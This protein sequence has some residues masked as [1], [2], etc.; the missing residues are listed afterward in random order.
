MGG[1][2]H[3][4]PLLKIHGFLRDRYKYAIPLA[5]ALS[6][7]GA[8]AGYRFTVP[9]Y[10]STGAVII[11]SN[12]PTIMYKTDFNSPMQNFDAYLALQVRLIL[13]RRTIDIA[14]QDPE[15]QEISKG[16][17]TADA[18]TEFDNK[19]SAGAQNGGVIEIYYTD[20]DPKIAMKA[21]RAVVAAYQK[22]YQESDA[23]NDVVRQK[24][25]ED[26]RVT[27]TNEIKSLTDSINA[28]SPEYGPDA[29]RKIYNDKLNFL[30]EIETRY[31]K[32]EL[33]LKIA[34]ATLAKKSPQTQPAGVTAVNAFE[35]QTAEQI[36]VY[37]PTM[38]DIMSRFRKISVELKTLETQLGSKHRSVVTL[39][40]AKENLAKQIQ[41]R[42][43]EINQS[44]KPDTAVESFI[45]PGEIMGVS[46]NTL[47]QKE[48][49]ERDLYERAK[50]ETLDLGRKVTQIDSLMQD[51]AEKE[52]NRDETK[53]RLDQIN[54]EAIVSG[55][56]NVLDPGNQ[57]VHPYNDKRIR[58][59]GVAGLGGALLG[60]GVFALVGLLDRRVKNLADIESAFSR[61]QRLLGIL[62]TLPD[63]LADP[64]QAAFAAHCVHRIRTMMEVGAGAGRRR[65]VTITS[66][67]PGDGKTSLTLALGLSFAAADSKTLLIDCD[68]V[69]GGLTARMKTIIRRKMGEILRRQGLLTEAQFENAL[70]ETQRTGKKLGEVIVE[71]GY[72]TQND[73]DH[74]LVMQKES[75]VGLLDV[76][77][78]APLG[79]SITGTGTPGLSILPLGSARAHLT[80][81]ISPKA[82]RRIIEEARQHYDVTLIDTGPLLGS[83]E[84]SIIATEADEVILAVARGEQRPLVEKAIEMLHSIGARLTG[85][86]YNRAK[87][88]DIESSDF[89]PSTRLSIMR[90]QPMD[91]DLGAAPMRAEGSSRLGPVAGAVVTSTQ[92]PD[93]TN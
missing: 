55:R 28:V 51:R 73:I 38:K 40:L 25:L 66:P 15:W 86:V 9:K 23:Q 80:G 53:K 26:R 43:D 65:V 67:M 68:V 7:A 35:S 20:P 41:E 10:R 82:I 71:L 37:D 60:L 85:V 17:F 27:L 24:A 83:L 1:E 30:N 63:D 3:V 74:A 18:V 19:L 61:T 88:E 79:D 69:G 62:P 76:L 42:M 81:H 45:L 49:L 11:Q 52:Q 47:R 58:N 46:I 34:E 39:T 22:V 48:L 75:A 13:S 36:E 70:T 12:V 78:G 87:P 54:T 33:D 92:A 14:L 4:S 16:H 31:K 56:M 21:V 8:W 77:D 32:A 89:S 90:S 2:R 29:L 50:A 59:A 44:T 91:L 6:V 57:P 93:Q 64:E 84:T 5:L 72:L